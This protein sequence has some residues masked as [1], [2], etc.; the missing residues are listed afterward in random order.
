MWVAFNHLVDDL[1]NGTVLCRKYIPVGLDLGLS[2]LCQ[3][4]CFADHQPWEY[5]T[6]Q[7]TCIWIYFFINLEI[8]WAIVLSLNGSITAIYHLW[9]IGWK[10]LECVIIKK[11]QTVCLLMPL[12]IP[13]A[14][15]ICTWGCSYALNS[16]FLSDYGLR[17]LYTYKL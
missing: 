3:M 14:L 6:C 12:L 11:K 7:C 1:W 17:Y 13:S 5:H 2:C 4:D 16:N 8:W 15:K 9:C 10:S